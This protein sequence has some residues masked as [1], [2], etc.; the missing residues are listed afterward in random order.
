MEPVDEL[1]E[2]RQ[3][4]LRI[5]VQ[6]YVDT[7]QPVASRTIAENYRLGVSPATI[8]ND[9]S[10]LERAGLLTHPHTSAGRVPTDAGYRYFVRH[11]LANTELPQS[12]RRMIRHQFHQA[13][14]EVDQWLRLSTAVLARASLSA[15]LATTP[16]AAESRFKH[17]ELVEIRDAVVLLVLVLQEG[18]VKQQIITL[19]APVDQSELSRTSNELNAKL[20]NAGVTRIQ[21]T[22][23]ALSGLA[24]E[25]AELVVEM[26]G[27]MNDQLGERI[28]RDGLAQVL[29]APEFAEGENMRRIV[30]VMEQRSLLEEVLAELVTVSDVQVLIAGEGRFVELED[31]SLV[32][33]RYGVENEATG[34]I[35]VIGPVRM[36]YARTIG[37]VR[38]VAGLM[39]DLMHQIYGK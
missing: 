16:R 21:A 36:P 20:A 2:R 13:R 28:Y 38:Y 35:G 32:L 4:I 7:T 37:A 5:V 27:R 10:A 39:S 29:E 19:E 18:A 34:M 31:I 15:A 11:L 8:R 26:M 12:E 30:Q 22:L 3:E 6:E 14:Q 33:S 1:S 17:L 23:P 25:V 9:L 24:G